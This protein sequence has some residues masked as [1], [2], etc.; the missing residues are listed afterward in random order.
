M[1]ES[2]GDDERS[3]QERLEA[4]RIRQGL[5]GSP[6]PPRPTDSVDGSVLGLGLRVGAELVAA[7]LVGVAI[8][9]GLDRVL[10]TR[11]V[12]LGVFI[13]IGGAA[14]VLNV[15]RMVAPRQ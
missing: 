3:L 6:K 1:N 8:G 15:W 13:L 10:G 11:P 7:L 5:D 12:F 9:W 2:P 4:A 14:G